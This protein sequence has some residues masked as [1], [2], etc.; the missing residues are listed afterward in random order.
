MEFTCIDVETANPNLSSICQIGIAKFKDGALVS[1]WESL[2]NPNDY[3]DEMNIAVHAITPKMVKAAPTLPDLHKTILG[4]INHSITVSHTSFDRSAVTQA[5]QKHGLEPPNTTWLDTA[6]VVRR[7]WP[8]FSKK[9]YGLANI[10][11]H[12]G[13]SFAHHNAL[14]DAVAC[15]KVLLR[16]VEITNC[17]PS[18]WIKKV[19]QPINPSATKYIRREGIEDGALFG[20][21]LVFTGA[22]SMTRSQ[23]ADIAAASG[24]Q[25]DAGVT[26]KTTI[27]VV[28]D[29][30]L[31]L[32]AGHEISNKH[33]KAINLIQS[34]QII[35]IL[36]ESDFLLITDMD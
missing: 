9:G 15:G 27:L 3:F 2:V 12:L 19:H 24:C 30:D 26:K 16:A 5:C 25:V 35:R 7:A 11:E 22:L 13:I 4:Q 1:Q 36:G 14:Q 29:Q 20:E 6:R 28:G 33:Q 32:L 31:K 34:G 18:D 10:T 21:R 8:Q 17:S 23:A